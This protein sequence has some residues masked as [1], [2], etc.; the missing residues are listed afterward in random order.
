VVYPS[1]PAQYFHV[2]RRQGLRKIKKPLVLFTPK[3]LLRLTACTSSLKDL[4]QGQFEEFLDDPL[5]PSKI[6]RLLICS[7][8]IFYD[9]LEARE[10]Q[11]IEGISILRIEQLY[12]FNTEKFI[13]I[14]A[15]YKGFQECYWVQ[16]EP[17]NM[18]SWTY[19]RPYL[20]DILKTPIRYIGRAASASPAAGSQIRHKE[21]QEEILKLALR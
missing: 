6:K 5:P 4:E 13:K 9:L 18:G 12:P 3:S 10:K 17:E 7:G 14:L 8:K 15:K 1:T 20:T 11:K 2:L 16:E 19:I 21:E